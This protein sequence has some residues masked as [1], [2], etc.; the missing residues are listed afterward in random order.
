MVMANHLTDGLGLPGLKR[1]RGLK[2]GLFGIF[3]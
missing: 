2:F 1:S 3:G